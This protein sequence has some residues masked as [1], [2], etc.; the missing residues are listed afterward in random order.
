MI[1]FKINLIK[2][3]F[4]KKLFV[5]PAGLEPATLWLEAIRAI[6]L[7]HEGYIYFYQLC[8]S[9]MFINYVYQLCLLIMFY[10]K[11]EYSLSNFKISSEKCSNIEYPL[12]YTL[13]FTK[14]P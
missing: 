1:F 14:S 6:R 13:N 10:L 7:R 2:Y 4:I 9:I 12:S 8:L 11:L 5:P 3:I